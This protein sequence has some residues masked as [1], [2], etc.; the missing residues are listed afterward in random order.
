MRRKK[1]P[2]TISLEQAPIHI[3]LVDIFLFLEHDPTHI[4]LVDIYPS[5]YQRT[6]IPPPSLSQR[7]DL[8]QLH[9]FY[10]Q[11]LQILS[12]QIRQGLNTA[13]WPLRRILQSQTYL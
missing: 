6:K 9:G 1:S 13:N 12:V 2:M 4:H 5:H 3:H 11:K 8:S 10:L 7:L